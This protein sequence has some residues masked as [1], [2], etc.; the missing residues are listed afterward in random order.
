M[1]GWRKLAAWAAVYALVAVAT[2]AYTV[3]RE[4]PETNAEVIKWVTGFFFGTNAVKAL[5]KNIKVGVGNGAK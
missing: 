5:F 4:I 3:P 1:I 2:L